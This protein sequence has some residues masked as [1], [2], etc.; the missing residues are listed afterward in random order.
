MDPLTATLLYIVGF[1]CL[2]AIIAGVAG[3]WLNYDERE[4]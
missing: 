1:V 2:L 3:A 4:R